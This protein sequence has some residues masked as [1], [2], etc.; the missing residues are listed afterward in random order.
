MP[1]CF[2]ILY[3]NSPRKIPSGDRYGDR[4]VTGADVILAAL[5]FDARRPCETKRRFRGYPSGGVLTQIRGR[6]HMWPKFVT[7]DPRVNRP[8]T[9]WQLTL[10][11]SFFGSRSKSIEKYFHSTVCLNMGPVP[12]FS[13][14]L[15]VSQLLGRLKNWQKFDV[16]VS[17]VATKGIFHSRKAAT[18]AQRW[19]WKA[20]RRGD[21]LQADEV[22]W[23][24]WRYEI[25]VCWI[26][27]RI[28]R[29]WH[30]VPPHTTNAGFALVVWLACLISIFS[31]N[32]YPTILTVLNSGDVPHS[33]CRWLKSVC[34]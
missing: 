5:I 21:V 11:F 23:D 33:Q 29:A 27:Q 10:A 4:V 12:Y 2:G 8:S 14:C 30:I 7:C 34:A 13:V 22:P 32:R 28:G 16:G 3:P 15:M 25:D 26:V 1:F 18:C 17:F 24:S 6:G 9:M 20:Q 31:T 19:A